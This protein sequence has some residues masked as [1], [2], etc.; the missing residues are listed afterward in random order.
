MDNVRLEAFICEN[1]QH[2]FLKCNVKRDMTKSAQI[3]FARTLLFFLPQ[4]FYDLWL[5]Q[6]TEKA[7]FMKKISRLAMK[8]R[9]RTFPRYSHTVMQQDRGDPATTAT[10]L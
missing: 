9:L 1:Q 7:A 8:V 4:A 10:V 6:D 3:R 5:A 2:S